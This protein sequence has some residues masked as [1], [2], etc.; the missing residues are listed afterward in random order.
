[1]M[2]WRRKES[3]Q[4][5]KTVMRAGLETAAKPLPELIEA[6]AQGANRF[7]RESPAPRVVQ[8]SLQ[9][10]KGLG[11]CV[12]RWLLPAMPTEPRQWHPAAAVLQSQLMARFHGRVLRTVSENLG[13]YQRLLGASAQA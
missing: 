13:S 12:I 4:V 6:F 2:S 10:G 9:A 3:Q 11:Y 1:M 8:R 5:D 7:G